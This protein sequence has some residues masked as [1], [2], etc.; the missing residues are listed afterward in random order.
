MTRAPYIGRFAAVAIA[1]LFVASAITAIS[2]LRAE[3]SGEVSY[4]PHHLS[5]IQIC[6][7]NEDPKHF[8]DILF[9]RWIQAV[10]PAMAGWIILGI[11]RRQNSVDPFSPDIGASLATDASDCNAQTSKTK[12]NG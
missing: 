7:R 8:R 9:Y 2:A 11:V 6:S 10:V 4:R 3:I 12:R 1:A 5:L